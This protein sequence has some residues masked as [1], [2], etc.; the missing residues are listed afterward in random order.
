[1][2]FVR[3][4]VLDLNIPFHQP[5]VSYC[6]ADKYKLTPTLL[7]SKKRRKINRVNSLDWQP[8]TW[9]F[10]YQSIC[11]INENIH[12]HAQC[13]YS[14]RGQLSSPKIRP[15]ETPQMHDN[16]PFKPATKVSLWQTKKYKTTLHNFRYSHLSAPGWVRRHGSTNKYDSEPGISHPG[17]SGL[18]GNPMI[19]LIVDYL[20]VSA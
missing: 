5:V 19:R 6:K 13:S 10:T 8:G 16:L 9:E 12:L 1:M 14:S 2:H 18:W 7:L 17:H 15:Q 4:C 11:R 20:S 3:A